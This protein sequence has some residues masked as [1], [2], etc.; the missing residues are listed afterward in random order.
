MIYYVN[1]NII[2]CGGRSSPIIIQNY[3]CDKNIIVEHLSPASRVGQS[4]GDHP[5]PINLWMI[6]KNS[7]YFLK[8]KLK[9]R[10]ESVTPNNKRHVQPMEEYKT[11]KHTY[12]NIVSLYS[13][14]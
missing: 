3:T 9:M 14:W 4:N 6:H 8:P 1:N 13:C 7:K 5:L 2:E 11:M 12:P 10:N